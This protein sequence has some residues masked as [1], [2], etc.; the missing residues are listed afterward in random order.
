MMDQHVATP[1][2]VASLQMQTFRPQGPLG[3]RGPRPGLATAAGAGLDPAAGVINIC[4]PSDSESAA[5]STES[6]S[7]GSRLP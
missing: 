5:T 7:W 1:T 2:D 3:T 4:V 6:A